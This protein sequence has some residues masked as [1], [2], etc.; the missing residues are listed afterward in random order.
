VGKRGAEAIRV[1]Y[2]AG[3]DG[4]RSF[5]RHALDIGFP[6]K[7]LGIRALFADVILTGVGRDAWH[8]LRATSIYP[9]KG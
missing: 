4:G 3:A 7:T 5:V 6:G 1:R 2:L 8:R 9:P